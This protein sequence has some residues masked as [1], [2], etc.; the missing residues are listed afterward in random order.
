MPIALPV[1]QL[2]LEL[3]LGELHVKYPQP[4]LLLGVLDEQGP[5]PEHPPSFGFVAQFPKP[6]TTSN[7][8]VIKTAPISRLLINVLVFI[9]VL[10]LLF[11]HVTATNRT[12]C[13]E[14]VIGT[15][16]LFT[17]RS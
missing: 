13:G 5:S 2:P 14:I 7:A 17:L 12:T 8:V 15:S 9:C 11:C 4:P 6:A 16:A 10:F 1:W 3:L